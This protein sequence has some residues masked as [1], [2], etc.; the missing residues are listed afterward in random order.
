MQFVVT[1]TAIRSVAATLLSIVALSA[2]NINR[3]PPVI[4]QIVTLPV[5]GSP[6]YTLEPIYSMT[7]KLTATLIPS[8]TP[9]P[10]ATL[11][12]S[13]TPT[14]SPPS[15][16]PSPSPIPTVAGAVN[17]TVNFR[18]GPNRTS[19]SL[20]L[21][22]PGTTLAIFGW[23][24]SKSFYLV[25]VEDG[26]RGWV[27]ASNI[28]VEDPAGIAVLPD[29]QVTFLLSVTLPPAS[30]T[31]APTLRARTPATNDILAYCDLPPFAAAD[32]GK[33]IRAG[34][35]VSIYWSWFAETPEQI[36]DHLDYGNYEVKLNGNLLSDW[37]KYRT[38]VTRASA[39]Q[40]RVYWYV[41]L[42]KLEAGEYTVTYALSWSQQIRDGSKTFGPGGDEVTNT[43][44]CK[45]T[46][47]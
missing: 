18:T 26:R 35:T 6:T 5:E 39:K 31:A 46:V 40:Y 36:Q 3:P 1:P 33:T 30:P 42:G 34:S 21:L 7:P 17:Q 45:F 9:I 32:G 28:A 4:T 13:L 44:T 24:A 38:G 25:R 27:Q 23:D 14:Q 10:S 16:T 43:G 29:P 20:G 12:P 47:K 41:P 19:E 15:S 22:Q 8:P 37:A 11:P 2:C